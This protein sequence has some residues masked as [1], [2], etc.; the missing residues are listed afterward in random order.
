MYIWDYLLILFSSYLLGS[1]SFA[2][3]IA[4]LH[5]V[6][7][8]KE[9]SGNPGATNIKRT[10]GSFWSDCVFLLD[11]SKGMLSLFIPYVLIHKPIY[12]PEL[13]SIICLVGALLGHSFSVF[14]K[15]KGGK[16][17]ATAMGGLCILMPLPFWIGLSTWILV[18]FLFRY[19]SIASIAFGISLPIACYTLSYP[20]ALFYLACAV[21]LII[22]SLHNKNI[23]RLI[24]GTE[25]KFTKPLI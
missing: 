23:K 13:A 14:L 17:V 15:F 21:M 3:I 25:N 2:T 7:I 24:Q 22:V 6:D 12:Q 1:I 4:K 16:G 8:F 18:F 9:G 10:L 11:F 5:G 19:V 20:S